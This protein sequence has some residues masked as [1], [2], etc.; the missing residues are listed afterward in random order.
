MEAR[1]LFLRRAAIVTWRALF[2]RRHSCTKGY[3]RLLGSFNCKKNHVRHKKITAP[4]KKGK[5]QGGYIDMLVL[6]RW[7]ISIIL[8]SELLPFYF[9]SISQ[10]T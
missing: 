10:L 6:K 4:F 3:L 7:I 5:K 9:N 2:H 1:C 8:K